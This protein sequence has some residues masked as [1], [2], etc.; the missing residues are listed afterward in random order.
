MRKCANI[1][2]YMRRPLVIYDF[3]TDTFSI[4]LYMRKFYFLFNQ[5]KAWP[6]PYGTRKL[7]RVCSIPTDRRQ[8]DGAWQAGVTTRCRLS[9]LT[10][11]ALV[12]EPKCEGGW[13]EGGYGV[14]ANEYSRAHGAQ[15]NWGDPT[16][17]LTYDD[18][19]FNLSFDD[20]KTWAAKYGKASLH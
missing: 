16:P 17:Y 12:Y 20:H 10:N 14:S 11:S 9:W 1:E 5:C 4:S 15:I 6:V 2:P 7:F 3:A 18:K 13:G 19:L 8:S